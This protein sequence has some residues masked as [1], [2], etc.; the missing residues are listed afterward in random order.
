M[1]PSHRPL[2]LLLAVIFALA[3]A[4]SLASAKTVWLCKP[5]ASPDPCTP[6]L[7]TTVFT[8]TGARIA[9]QHP[10]AVARTRDRL[11]LRL[12]DG[13]RP[14]DR[15]YANLHVDP[16]R[17]LDRALPGRALFA[18]LPRVRADVPAGD[19]DRHCWPGH[20]EDPG[21]ADDSGRT[22]STQRLRRLPRRLQPRSRVRAHRPLAGLV[23]AAQRDRQRRSTRTRPCA[24]GWCRRSCSAATCW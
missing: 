19:A 11:L 2:L 6:G 9:V 24:G 7:S 8:P 5:G 12:P 22:M 21:G 13:Q 18:V 16:G 4:P 20:H 14:E 17:A 15:H 3:A 10:K 1:R 23:R